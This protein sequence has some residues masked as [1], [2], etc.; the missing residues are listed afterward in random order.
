MTAFLYVPYSCSYQLWWS[1]APAGDATSLLSPWIDKFSYFDQSKLSIV[2]FRPLWKV[3]SVFEP[4][5]SSAL[6]GDWMSYYD[7][8]I[9][10][11]RWI[12]LMEYS[13]WIT[14]KCHS[15][16]C[17]GVST[18]CRGVVGWPWCDRVVGMI[19]GINHYKF[20]V[21]IALG[22]RIEHGF[23]IVMKNCQRGI[24]TIIWVWGVHVIYLF[25]RFA[26]NCMLLLCP[27]VTYVMST[28]ND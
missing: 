27:W 23:V 4:P 11:L 22:A 15:L 7:S 5:S 25:I 10:R 24:N 3:T 2:H 17:T 8:W 21:F 26:Y 6:E 13:I 16:H 12:M 14:L 18:L 9:N 19:Q 20:D 28:Y 1:W